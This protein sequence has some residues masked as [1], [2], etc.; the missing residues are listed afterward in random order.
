VLLTDRDRALREHRERKKEQRETEGGVPW[1]QRVLS[2]NS[3]FLTFVVGIALNLPGALY[4]VALKDIAAADLATGTTVFYV[5]LYNLIMFQ[6][7]E[8]PL[9][10]YAVAPERTEHVIRSLNDWLGTHA[11]QI[12]ISLCAVAAVYLIVQGLATA[13]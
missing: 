4:L 5:L 7:A 13:T 2:R 9:V 10:G 6:W 8:I 3:L 12:A 11:R 1:S